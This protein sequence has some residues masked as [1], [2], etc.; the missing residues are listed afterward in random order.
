MEGGREEGGRPRGRTGASGADGAARHEDATGVE[1][2]GDVGAA[3][4][5]V[6]GRWLPV[7]GHEGYLVSE[8]GDVYS[9][10]SHRLLAGSVGRGGYRSVWLKGRQHALVH[11]L[12]IE[13][14]VGPPPSDKHMVA[15]GNGIPSDN[16]LENLRW[17][18]GAENSADAK[19][20]GTAPRGERHGMAKL[21]PYQVRLIRLLRRDGWQVESVAQHF[22][23]AKSTVSEIARGDRWASVT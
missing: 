19:A 15:H 6:A 22:G 3:V 21:T 14:F 17:A 12:V 8:Q 2:P 1:D 20:H 11:R 13:A 7:V 18:T 16:R 4:V 5:E 9:H 10:Y 23:I